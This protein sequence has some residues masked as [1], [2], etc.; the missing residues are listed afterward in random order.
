MA[1]YEEG[2][3]EFA[4]LSLVGDPLLRLVP[5]LA[6]N[7][8]S[9]AALSAQLDRVKPDW[10]DF[11]TGSTN[12]HL[13]EHEGLVSGPDPAYELTQDKFDQAKLSE[14]VVDLC[15]GDVAADIMTHRQ[16]LINAQAELRMSIKEELQSNVSDEER[17][18]ARGCD[19][20]ASMQ[21]FI[22]KLRTKKQAEQAVNAAQAEQDERD[23]PD[24]LA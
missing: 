8:K 3:I 23:N 19:Y 6:E 5:A 11:V 9:I 10:Q 7:I 13:A 20:G 4:I 15:L 16:E 14:K 18:T 21:S 24:K 2:Q 1:L 12:G 17:A 22:R